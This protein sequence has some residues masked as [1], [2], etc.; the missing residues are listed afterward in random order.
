MLPEVE[1]L[2]MQIY[3]LEESDWPFSENVL[4]FGELPPEKVQELCE[5]LQPS[6]VTEMQMNWGPSRAN[7][8]YGRKYVNLWWD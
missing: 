4:I 6:E 7:H 2:W 1:E 8:L 5:S 3:A